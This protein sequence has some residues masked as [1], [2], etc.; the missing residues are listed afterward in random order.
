M[1]S[2]APN[3]TAQWRLKNLRKM[4]ED[5]REALHQRLEKVFAEA[6]QTLAGQ[7]D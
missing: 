1:P 4:K 2:R 5:R 3:T 6:R 7:H